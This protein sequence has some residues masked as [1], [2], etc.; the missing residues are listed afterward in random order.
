MPSPVK[1]KRGLYALC[2]S[3]FFLTACSPC[4][5]HW[6]YR[7]VDACQ[8][9]YQV[10]RLHLPPEDNL[11][12]VGIEIVHSMFELRIYLDIYCLMIPPYECQEELGAF[13]M[14]IDGEESQWVV[15]RLAGGQRL[16]LTPEASEKLISALL[17]ESQV[18]I[19]I[20]RYRTDVTL[21]DFVEG[22]AK[23]CCYPE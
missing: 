2:L 18:S 6:I 16:W 12:Q 14:I 7:Q 15:H 19:V 10:S 1:D 11:N 21:N 8:P 22:Y 4:R 23:L 17:D 9:C 5:P 13:K 3:A 20:G